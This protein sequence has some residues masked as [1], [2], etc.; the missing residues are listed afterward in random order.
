WV[1]VREANNWVPLGQSVWE[2]GCG[3]DYRRKAEADYR[4][5]TTN[6]PPG[7]DPSQTTFVFVTPRRWTET[8]VDRAKW[9][10]QRRESGPWKDVRVHDADALASWLQQAPAVAVWFA[11]RSGRPGPLH[12]LEWIWSEWSRATI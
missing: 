2:M 11:E 12:T 5:R 7:I 9:E 6:V 3:E 1:K 10:Q 8:K 4:K